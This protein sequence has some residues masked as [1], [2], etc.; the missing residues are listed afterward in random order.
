MEEKI[1]S[2]L[3]SWEEYNQK[4]FE[5]PYVFSI[6]N[7]TQELVY[8]GTRHCYDPDDKEFEKIREEWDSFYRR[9][10][11]NNLLVVVEGGVRSIEKSEKEAI[12]KGGEMS[13]ITFLADQKKVSSVC[14]EPTRGEVF[15]ELVKKYSKEKIFYQRIAQVILQWNTLIERP[16]FEEYIKYFLQKD[17]DQSNWADFDFSLDNLKKIHTDLFTTE[18]NESDRDFFYKIVDP[19]QKNTII[20][21]ISRDEDIVRDT[22]VVKGIIKEWQ[23]RKSIFIVYGSGHAVIQ[24]RAL[25]NLLV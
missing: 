12:I 23:N 15:D 6:K 25:R 16:S 19:T 20:N 7:D 5:V 4:E 3:L 24:E 10:E 17:K 13:F 18:F 1:Q 11:G 2:L 14:F 22:I 8:V 21:E 9:N